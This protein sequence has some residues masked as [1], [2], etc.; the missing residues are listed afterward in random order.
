MSVVKVP[1]LGGLHDLEVI[2][3]LVHVGDS[4]AVDQPILILETEKA[5]MEIVSDQA[6]I[7]QELLLKKG[8]KVSAGMIVLTLNEQNVLVTENVSPP[9][10]EQKKTEVILD[11]PVLNTVIPH[12]VSSSLN[13]YAGPAVRKLARELNVALEGIRGTGLHGRITLDDLKSSVREKIKNPNVQQSRSLPDFSQWGAVHEQKL[14]SIQQ[15]S[16]QAMEANWKAIPHVTQF[17][18]A[19]IT[20][21]EQFRLQQQD[22]ASQQGTKLTPLIFVIK[23]VITSLKKFPQF[24]SSFSECGTKIIVKD[25]INIGIAVE[26]EEGLVVPV[27]HDANRYSL[28]ELAS[29]LQELSTLARQRRLPLAAMT[30]QTFTISSLGGIGGVGFTPII[31]WPDVAILGVSK[32]QEQAKWRDDRWER[33]RVLPLSLSYDHRVIDGAQ[34]ARFTAHV[35]Q[36]LEDIRILLL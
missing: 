17:D 15:K 26:T 22:K 35:V 30:G 23:A 6:G 10:V 36:V 28:L 13:I 24:N 16:A 33:S 5:S 31:N 27:I 14:S 12:P 8:D 25:Y 20:A 29:R 4:L 34:A 7:V 9:V 19:D 1:A 18:E 11:V 3:I 32:I 21:L 2:D